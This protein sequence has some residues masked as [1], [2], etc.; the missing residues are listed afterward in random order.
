MKYMLMTF[1]G[2]ADLAGRPTAWI[3]EMIAFMRRIDQEL[4]ASGELVFQQGLAE[5]AQAKTVRPYEGIP[6]A[7]DG[8][9]ADPEGS[10]AGFWIV[11]VE[12]EAR[13]LDIAAR[14]SAAADAPIEVRPCMDAPP[15]GFPG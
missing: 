6:V 2:Q 10:L 14:I 7:T 4:A 3:A 13:A 8:A 12:D 15:D 9:Y 1:G 11:D 5:A